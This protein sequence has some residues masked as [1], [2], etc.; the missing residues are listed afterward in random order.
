MR[1]IHSD[2]ITWRLQ[3]AR[4]A[5]FAGGG[6]ALELQRAVAIDLVGNT[7]TFAFPFAGLLQQVRQGDAGVLPVVKADA[8]YSRADGFVYVR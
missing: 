1:L 3:R 4:V 5:F 7:E 6:D 8:F 2:E